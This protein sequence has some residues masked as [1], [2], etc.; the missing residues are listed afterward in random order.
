MASTHALM[1]LSIRHMASP[2]QKSLWGPLGRLRPVF[3]SP[4]GSWLSRDQATPRAMSGS[5]GPEAD[6]GEGVKR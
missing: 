6:L 5:S 3:Q 2:T 1:A 4:L